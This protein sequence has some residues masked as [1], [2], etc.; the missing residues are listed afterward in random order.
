MIRV[1]SFLLPLFIMIS[2]I[3]G[4]EEITVNADASGTFKV[5]YE[6]PS[7]AAAEIGP[8]AKYRRELERIDA[9][10]EGIRITHQE[11]GFVRGKLLIHVEAEFDDVT[12]LLEIADRQQENFIEGTGI[13]PGKLENLL[14]G[15]HFALEG[16]KADFSRRL[17]IGSMLPEMVR[18]D[19]RLLLE[20]EFRFTINLPIA[21]ES[22]N[23][24]ELSADRKSM[25]WKFLLRDYVDQPIVMKFRTEPLVPWWAWIF[26]TGILLLVLMGLCKL[27]RFLKARP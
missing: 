13:G 19:P 14:G 3:D 10:E 22:S 4:E 21:I 17:E 20:S 9:E 7:A 1:L 18:N 8:P 25:S 26:L 2:C 12:D 6:F 16:M 27:V 23:A 5:R 15:I 11:I 24:A